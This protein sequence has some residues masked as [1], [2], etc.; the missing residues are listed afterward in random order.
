[1]A[2]DLGS[3][4]GQVTQIRLPKSIADHVSTI[5]TWLFAAGFLVLLPQLMT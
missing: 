5:H 3:K 2:E 4:H 1:M